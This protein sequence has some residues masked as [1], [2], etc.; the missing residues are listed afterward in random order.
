MTIID[1]AMVVLAGLGFESQLVKTQPGFSGFLAKAENG[2]SGYF[3]WSHSDSEDYQFRV[4]RFWLGNEQ[5]VGFTDHNLISAVSRA[6][7]LLTSI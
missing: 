3:V 2:V 1:D 5:E 6:K 7:K 4:A